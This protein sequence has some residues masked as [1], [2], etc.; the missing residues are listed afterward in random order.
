MYHG[1]LKGANDADV[2][3]FW[4]RIDALQR[5]S[6]ATSLAVQNALKK[7]DAMRLALARTPEAP[8]DLDAQLHEL[9]ETLLDLDEQ[10]NGNRAKREV[11]EKNNPTIRSRLNFAASGTRRS[12]YGPTPNL[13]G[14]LDIAYSE[15]EKLEAQLDRILNQLLPGMEKA[16]REAGAPWIEG[17]PIPRP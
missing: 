15:F 2:A 3:A 6:S 12:T 10:L 7:V 4:Q 16:L 13:K 8:G 14:S 11:G 17:Q 1:A 5:S 9:R